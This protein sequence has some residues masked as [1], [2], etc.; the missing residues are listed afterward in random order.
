MDSRVVL[1]RYCWCADWYMADLTEINGEL[2]YYVDASSLL[3]LYGLLAFDMEESGL[4][5]HSLRMESRKWKILL[6]FD[7]DGIST[8]LKKLIELFGS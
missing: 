4:G 1:E 6:N 2:K 3:S 7:R 5:I 8:L